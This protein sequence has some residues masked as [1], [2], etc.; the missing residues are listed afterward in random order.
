M[1]RAL[2]WLDRLLA[3]FVATLVVGL[4]AIVTSQLVDRHFIDIPIQA[5]D[6]YARIGLVWLTFL[7]FALA[8][9]GNVAVRV[10]I[11]DHYLPPAARRWLGIVSDAMLLV[12][13]CVLMVKGWAVYEVGAG[14]L[15]LGTPFTAGLP[16]AALV[17]GVV[18]MI[19][20]VALRLVARCRGVEPVPLEQPDC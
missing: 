16:N 4:V 6:Q 1:R 3:W 11:I 14:Q 5:P 17:A 19:L 10:D 2:R 18:L 7:G 12:M 8:I 13:L 9:R 15:I 20:Y